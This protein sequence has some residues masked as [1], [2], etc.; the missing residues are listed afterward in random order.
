[1]TDDDALIADTVRCRECGRL[2]GRTHAYWCP[3]FTEPGRQDADHEHV[4]RCQDC[5]EI[6]LAPERL[7]AELVRDH[8]CCPCVARLTEEAHWLRYGGALYGERNGSAKLCD[9]QVRALRRRY[10]RGERPAVLQELFGI[11]GSTFWAIVQR[12]TWRHVD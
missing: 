10:T 4:Y 11:K 3:R 6:G 1:M 9:D 8:T 12:R 5:D 7:S 2:D